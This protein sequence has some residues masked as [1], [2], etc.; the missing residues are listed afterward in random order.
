VD[1]VLFLFSLIDKSSFDELHQQISRLTSPNDNIARVVV[2]TKYPFNGFVLYFTNIIHT[3]K[4]IGN[5]SNIVPEI[6]KF[7]M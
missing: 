2:A 1:A 3:F 5:V 4:W 6:R 7:Y